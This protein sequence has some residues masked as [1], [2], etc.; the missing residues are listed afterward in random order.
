MYIKERFS[1]YT[2]YT[3]I[4]IYIQIIVL[5]IRVCIYAYMIN[6]HSKHIYNV[7]NLLF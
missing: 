1:I 5:Y 4:N 2:V 7:N 6:I 3:S